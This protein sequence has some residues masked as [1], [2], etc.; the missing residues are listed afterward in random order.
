VSA[1][2]GPSPCRGPARTARPNRGRSRFLV[3][4]VFSP[5]R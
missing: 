2:P 3:T 1:S 5:S 4:R